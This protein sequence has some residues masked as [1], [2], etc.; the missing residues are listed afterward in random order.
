MGWGIGQGLGWGIGQGV[1]QDLSYFSVLIFV[2][3]C[4]Q[5]MCSLWLVKWDSW[6]CWLLSYNL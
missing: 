3:E 5:S 4:Y 6:N 1:G 2:A